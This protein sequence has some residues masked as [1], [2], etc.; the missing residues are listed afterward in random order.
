MFNGWN[1]RSKV[2]LLIGH[3]VICRDVS[4]TEVVVEECGRLRFLV[5]FMYRVAWRSILI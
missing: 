3:R 2:A 1:E 4:E 5:E